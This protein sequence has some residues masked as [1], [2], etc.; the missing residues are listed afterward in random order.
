MQQSGKAEF[1]KLVFDVHLP[2]YIKEIEI[3]KLGKKATP[4][5]TQ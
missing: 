2:E 4:I 1:D 3:R 5:K